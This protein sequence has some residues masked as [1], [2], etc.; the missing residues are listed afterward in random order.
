M[1]IAPD[2]RFLVTGD[3][4]RIDLWD[5][6]SGERVMSWPRPSPYG[7]FLFRRDDQILASH[8]L[9]IDMRSGRMTES[10]EWG[11]NWAAISPDGSRLAAINR[12]GTVSFF[13]LRHGDDFAPEL[14]AAH[15]GH[16]DHGRSV[17]FSPDGR[18]VA[19]A[20]EDI[21]LWDAE[22]LTKI[23]RLEFPSIV[24]SVAFSPDGRFLA[25]SHGDGSV[26]IWDVA[27]R[28]RI[29]NLNEHGGSVRSVAFSRDGHR[30]LSAGE[31]RTVTVW[32]VQRGRKEAVLA[33]HKSR[34]TAVAISDDGSVVASGDQLGDTIL[35]DLA[36]RR[37]HVVIAP[38]VT[39]ASYVATLSPDGSRLVTTNGIYSS[40]GRRLVPFRE[41]GWSYGA[42]YAAVFFRDT[43][44]LGAVTDNG[45]VMIWDA[46]QG[47]LIAHHQL[48]RTPIVALSVSTNG[49]WLVTGD[50]DGIVRLWSASPLRPAG[51]VGRHAAR[52][53]SVS[54][55][56]DGKTVASAGDDKTI[57]LWD[58][59]RKK[60][61]AR[62]GTHASPVYAVAFSPDGRRIVSGEH[63]HTVRVYTMQRTLWGFRLN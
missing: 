58:V 36:N 54:F 52:V 2:G 8:N 5:T 33:G 29:A 47:R 1:G 31:D 34:V 42:T 57:A 32:N 14:I 61:R 51:I 41:A 43:A 24:W 40:D 27:E 12:L 4:A 13:R 37:P 3:A 21:L 38:P 28:A 20:A 49:K 55:S 53:K 16:Q 26:L 39:N 15:P 48:S 9:Q 30:V 22:T 56:P 63:D 59:R 23:A 25:S 6:G 7:T 62:I 45:W 60:L 35:W 46:Q 50:D 19:S 11:G 44:R 18:L 10:H 17:A